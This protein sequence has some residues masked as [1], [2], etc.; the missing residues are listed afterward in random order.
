[1]SQGTRRKE[2]RG[3]GRE[4]GREGRGVERRKLVEWKNLRL[5]CSSKKV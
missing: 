5:Q 1:M 4:E 2:E 3:R